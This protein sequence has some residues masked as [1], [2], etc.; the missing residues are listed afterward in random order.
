MLKAFIFEK[1]TLKDYT[2]MVDFAAY[3]LVIAR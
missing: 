1:E 2:Y 3:R